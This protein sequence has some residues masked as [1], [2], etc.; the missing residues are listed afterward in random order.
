MHLLITEKPSAARAFE[1]AL[2]GRRGTFEGV[3]YEIVN[4]RGHLYE[5]IPE[6][7][8]QLEDSAT[9]AERAK[10][11]SW[12]LANLPWDLSRFTW[13]Y[14]PIKDTAKERREIGEAM[15]R[16][17]VIVC[18]TDVDPSGEGG[19]IWGNI[20]RELGYEG[21]KPLERM[22]FLDE[23]VPSL[24]KGFRER[25]P[26][27]SLGTFG[28]YR[29]SQMRS[30]WD[31]ASMQFTRAATRAVGKPGTLLRQ[32]RLKSAMLLLVGDQLKAYNAYVKVVR[33]Q[34]RFRDENG[35]MYTDP[36]EPIFDT[37]SQVPRSYTASAVVVDEKVM[38]STAP[39]KFLDL[40]A[41]S[42]KLA[43][44]G[45]SADSVLKTYQDMYE[46]S[47][48]SYPRTE[49]RIISVE[50]HE[51]MLPL[52]EKV[53]GVVGVDPSI[54][55]HT[56]PRRTHVKDGGA[57]GANRPGLV[58]PPSMSEIRSAH[59]ELGVLIYDEVARSWLA[60]L[61]ED[62]QYE[63]QSG[64]LQEYP[65]FLGKTAVP[66]APGWKAVRETVDEDES[67][68]SSS[69]LGTN[70][71]PF[72]HE[73]IP[74]RPAY[75]TMAWLMKQLERGAGSE[76]LDDDAREPIGTGATRTSTFAEISA[77][78]SKQ[79]PH[80][81]FVEK[82]GRISLTDEGELG[83]L[84]LPGTK[85]GS[86]GITA[87]VFDA[88]RRVAA[89]EVT[90]ESELAKVADLVVHDVAKMQAN[91]E[92]ARAE[93][94]IGGAGEVIGVFTP[95]GQKV[96]FAGAFCD[97]VY[98]ESEKAALLA[99]EE[100][101]FEAVSPRTGKAFTATGRLGE[102][103]WKGKKTFGFQLTGSP[104]GGSGTTGVFAPTGEQVSFRAS[105]GKRDFTDDEIAALLRGESIEFEATSA[106]GSVYMAQ[107]K[108]KHGSYNGKETFGFEFLDAYECP[109]SVMGRRFSFDEVRRLESGEQI[110]VDGL[111]SRGKQVSATLTL[112]PSDTKR[113]PG[114][115][116]LSE[117]TRS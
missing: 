56:K 77:P 11:A 95:T 80:P 101:S 106:K 33:Y 19:S 97:H 3:D 85:I 70:A 78:K 61:C 115:I 74:P 2:G 28:E 53:A 24:Q 46:K 52:R 107:G 111:V 12:D 112:E 114:K 63:A 8:E 103:E 84:V 6:P 10:V 36:E 26:I 47:W 64:H 66:K 71:D 16:A 29:M 27:A 20:V 72:I 93:H 68:E 9:E 18:A 108:L 83:Y 35:V 48:V 50:Q 32:G 91:A 59:G 69:G 117:I 75:P 4:A 67:D 110:R 89:G 92:A 94:G 54:L 23:S 21:K 5:L 109:P 22:R 116:K 65:T 88:M 34:N 82:K 102:G 43:S 100:I 49:D 96:S 58:V 17:D 1:K 87:E 57:H 113:G 30:A 44:K 76:N 81:L 39:P 105:F 13:T 42:A 15:A 31:L 60:S 38:K 7:V 55:T 79:R 37:E 40:S 45:H 62:Y 41:L 104:G 51:E 14:R 90:A 98:S 99:G 73:V 25:E 86:L